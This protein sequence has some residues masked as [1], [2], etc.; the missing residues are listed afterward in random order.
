[1]AFRR[2]LADSSGHP[3]PPAPDAP[4]GGWP[5]G[6]PYGCATRALDGAVQVRRQPVQ[7]Q[8]DFRGASLGPELASQLRG[9]ATRDDDR[10]P[11]RRGAP[12]HKVTPLAP[13]DLLNVGKILLGSCLRDVLATSCHQRFSISKALILSRE[14]SKESDFDTYLVKQLAPVRP[15]IGIGR[16]AAAAP[17]GEAARCTQLVVKTWFLGGVCASDAMF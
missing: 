4:R 8:E 2:S 16:S 9:R 6:S 5:A 3:V 11:P 1:M 10:W 15:L 13:S 14:L 17:S 12:R 7:P